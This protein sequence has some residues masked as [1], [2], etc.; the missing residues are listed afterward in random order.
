M[1]LLHITSGV[2]AGELLLLNLFWLFQVENQNTHFSRL[3]VA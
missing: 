2:I 3:L 1:A